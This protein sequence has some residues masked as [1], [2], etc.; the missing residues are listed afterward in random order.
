MKVT[1][2]GRR[3]RRGQ[4]TR[5]SQDVTPAI[6]IDDWHCGEQRPCI[7]MLRSRKN[8]IDAAVLDDAAKVHHRNLV[9]E[10]LHHTHVVCDEEVADAI[11]TL[12][13]QQQV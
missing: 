13:I 7:R 9:R 6:R 12:Q 11:P 1:A 4:V 2:R 10:I 5:D 8:L 3:N